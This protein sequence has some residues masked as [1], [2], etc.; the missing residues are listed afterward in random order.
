MTPERWERLCGIYHAVRDL[1]GDD[2]A[3]ALDEHCRDDDALRRE[4]LA[5]LDSSGDAELHLARLAAGAGIASPDAEDLLH[6]A[7]REIGNYR[8]LRILGRGGMGVV[9]L[10]ERADGLYEKRIALKLLPL[11]MVTPEA[12][13]RFARE[14][15]ILAQLDHPGIARLMDGGVTD[16]GTPYFVMDFVAGEP[17]DEYCEHNT[18]GL[19]DRL[20][21]FREICA[22]VDYA[23]RHLV[24]HRDIKP[25]NILVTTEGEVRLLDFGVAK[26]LDPGETGE[27]T[28]TRP[29][30][31]YIS[32]SYAAPELLGGAPV[33]TACDV[34]ALGMVLYELLAGN[35][36]FDR[37]KR[38]PIE[39]MEAVRDLRPEPPSRRCVFGTTWTRRLAGDLDTITLKAL[40]A[41]PERRYA[42]V[43][44]LQEDLE[45][46]RKG[47]PV[48]ARPDSLGYRV[49]RFWRRHRLVAGLGVLLGLS[50]IGGLAASLWQGHQA[51]LAR[52]RAELSAERARQEAETS[53]R[54][55]RFLGDLFMTA[56]PERT[57][58]AP[59]SALELLDKGAEMVDE[60]FPDDPAIRAELKHK[61]AGIYVDYQMPDK[62]RPL[63]E[64]AL[65]TRRRVLGPVHPDTAHVLHTLG[66]LAY[67]NGHYEDALERLEEVRRALEANPGD[68]TRL[69]HA[70]NMLGMVH[71][72]L[73]RFEEAIADYEA[74]IRIFGTEGGK[75]DPNLG[76]AL[77]NLGLVYYE[78]SRFEEA[79]ARLE[80]ALAIHEATAGP[81]HPMVAGTLGNIAD[82]RRMNGETDGIVEPLQRAVRIMESA[83]GRDHPSTGVQLGNLARALTALGDLDEAETLHKE[84]IDIRSRHMGPDHVYNAYNLNGLGQIYFK[85]NDPAGAMPYLEE[86]LA[87]RERAFGP[88]HP[89]VADALDQISVAYSKMQDY[90][91][92]RQRSERA[93][94][95]RREYFSE[96]QVELLDSLRGVAEFRAATDDCESAR[97]LLSEVPDAA[98]SEPSPDTAKTL[99][100]VARFCG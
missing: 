33:T 80:K 44:D 5:L 96:G 36:P 20:R 31:R 8:L 98:G 74:A 49:S 77:N 60:K 68:P 23:H 2:L 42:T 53:E 55:A 88:D 13:Q 21:L 58:G 72:R 86:A 63:L 40:S 54:V 67:K 39:W 12:R 24:I 71:K 16:E 9:Y 11:G 81:D 73:G 14:R 79:I 22:A 10:A 37:D 30:R 87:V 61:L 50:V 64:Q 92:A 83:W 28:A 97:A 75:Q 3:S 93:L 6:A 38:S 90:P 100:V 78:M 76:R 48:A 35:A 29:D 85:R 52:D 66:V 51:A 43:R 89:D 15:A 84:A 56:N 94:E 69:G 99:R 47:L 18:T 65:E 4:V 19:R 45:R 82:A 34:Y 1:H 59:L 32:P 62:A 95:I 57:D 27:P 91:N 70:L 17:L 26:L 41:E 7:G 25:S 46:H